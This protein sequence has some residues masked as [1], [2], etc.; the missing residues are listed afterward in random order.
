MMDEQGMLKAKGFRGMTKCE[1][2]KRTEERQKSTTDRKG[3]AAP[4]AAEVR[5]GEFEVS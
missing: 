5:K 1:G 4:D 3:K 2:M